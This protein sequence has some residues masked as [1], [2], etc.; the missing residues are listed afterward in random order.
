MA[1]TSLS[2]SLRETIKSADTIFV[3]AHDEGYLMTTSQ[4]MSK[5]F[6]LPEQRPQ[7]PERATE[8]LTRSKTLHQRSEYR[9]TS[10]ERLFIQIVDCTN[11]EKIGTTVS[12]HST[13]SSAR[14]LRIC[15][16]EHIPAGSRIDLWVNISARPGKFFLSADVR[17]SSQPENGLYQ[18][19]VELI[20]GPAT[21]TA[22][23]RALH[24]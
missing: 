20:N 22:A 1:R 18:F 15:A 12:C 17:W 23:W 16:D 9:R 8:K 7:M 2:T 14:G 19:G 11:A 10:V 21:D 24:T 3:A 13:E 6:N 4:L 5:L